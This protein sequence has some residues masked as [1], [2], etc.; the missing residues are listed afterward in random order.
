MI[1]NVRHVN[2]YIYSIL[3]STWY[4]TRSWV[5]CEFLLVP[6]SLVYYTSAEKL[7][8]WTFL[9]TTNQLLSSWLITYEILI[10]NCIPG[11]DRFNKPIQSLVHVIENKK[12]LWPYSCRFIWRVYAIPIV[13]YIFPNPVLIG[14][15]HST[16]QVARAS[17]FFFRQSNTRLNRSL[18]DNG[19]GVVCCRKIDCLA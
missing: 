16:S 2:S 3:F 8:F 17:G 6:A 19:I 4:C 11:I 13:G 1:P 5:A 15:L 18:F 14:L 9:V 12:I 7:Q 10:L